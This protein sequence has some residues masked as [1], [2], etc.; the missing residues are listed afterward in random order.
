[1]FTIIIIIII[2][3]YLFL[4]CYIGVVCIRADSVFWPLAVQL[5]M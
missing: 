4:F 1:M 5:S 3:I 2:I